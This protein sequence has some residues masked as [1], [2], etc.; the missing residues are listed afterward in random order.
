M[1]FLHTSDW[2]IGRSLFEFSLLEDQQKIFEQICSI[3]E[4]EQVDAIL[5]SGDLYDRSLPSAQAV[6]LLDE[7]FTTLIS[8]F[9]LPI[10]AISGNHDSSRRVAYGSRLFR[11]NG[12]YLSGGWNPQLQKITLH[13][14]YG[15][16]NFFL[17]PYF[18]PQQVR[19][20]YDD[21]EIHTAT[22][23][24]QKII[25]QNMPYIDTTER[26]VLLA[27]GFFMRQ[28]HSAEDCEQKNGTQSF[29]Q[30]E[31]C[32]SE[33]SVG[34]SDL[35]DLWCAD[36]FDYVALGHLHSA[37]RAGSEKMRYSGSPLKYS[38]DEAKR[39]KS[40]TIV[41]LKEKGTFSV[42]TVPLTPARDLRVIE[43]TMD[44]LCQNSLAS[45]DYVFAKITSQG[46][47]LN[48]MSRL[49][50]YYPHTLGLSF[51]QQ[52]ATQTANLS[53]DLAS[54]E[55]DRLFE[56]FYAQVSSTSLEESKLKIVRDVLKAASKQ[57][58]D[59]NS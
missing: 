6:G 23:A 42:K 25:E 4:Q 53:T 15:A 7:M 2:H 1:K 49:R 29:S 57:D 3:I 17:L 46:P 22:Q 5:I 13:D 37:Q 10:F 24:F 36:F 56:L 34:A 51:E 30:P 21:P 38:V 40:V 20:G 48:A 32:G 18:I 55:P 52:L 11:K 44:E 9:H 39:E 31:S 59:L 50:Q 58:S 12:L 19:L 43:G 33:T 26:N 16:V 54:M 27:H 45:D 41:E 14:S 8:R 47:V 28:N 35:T